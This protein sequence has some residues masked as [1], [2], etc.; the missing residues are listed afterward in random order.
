MDTLFY[1]VNRERFLNSLITGSIMG[2]LVLSQSLFVNPPLFADDI[3][4]AQMSSP[5]SLIDTI[6]IKDKS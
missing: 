2:V 3:K 1:A 4:L 6:E 5:A